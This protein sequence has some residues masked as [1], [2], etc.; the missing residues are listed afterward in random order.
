[1]YRQY[2]DTTTAI[3]GGFMKIEIEKGISIPKRKKTNSLNEIARSMDIGD[4]VMFKN[5]GKAAPLRY[6]INR[7]GFIA[8]GRTMTDGYRLWKIT[9]RPTEDL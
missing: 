1:M 6:A 9:R 8:L 4:S 5:S 2:V 3:H 7:I